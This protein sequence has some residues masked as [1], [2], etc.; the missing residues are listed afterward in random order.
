MSSPPGDPCTFGEGCLTFHNLGLRVLTLSHYNNMG[1][2]S[3]AFSTCPE[4]HVVIPVEAIRGITQRAEAILCPNPIPIRSRGIKLIGLITGV[5]RCEVHFKEFVGGGDLLSTIILQ[6]RDGGQC[7]VAMCGLILGG[8]CRP[9]LA[10]SGLCQLRFFQPPGSGNP[11]PFSQPRRES[12]EFAETGPY[13][14]TVTVT[15]TPG[16]VAKCPADSDKG[17]AQPHDLESVV[18][19]GPDLYTAPSDGADRVP[20][21]ALNTLAS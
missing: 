8:V 19:S 6:S 18:V 5:A 21:K 16:E 10:G 17:R 20:V 13:F 3:R 9:R 12:T 11:T 14:V 4:V 2:F 1:L 7:G 15:A